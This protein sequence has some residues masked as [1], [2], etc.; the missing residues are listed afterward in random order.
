M[1]RIALLLLRFYQRVLSP[2]TPGMCRYTPTC[3]HY[4]YEAIEVHGPLRGTWLALRRLARCN[5]WG[6]MGHDPVPP[7]KSREAAPTTSP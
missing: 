4:A 5:P 3:S 7:A 2:Y 6:G 1:T